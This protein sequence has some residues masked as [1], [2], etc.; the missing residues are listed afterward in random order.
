MLPEGISECCANSGLV[1]GE[2]LPVSSFGDHHPRQEQKLSWISRSL[3]RRSLSSFPGLGLTSHLP[4]CSVGCA[5]LRNTPGK[6]RQSPAEQDVTMIAEPTDTCFAGKE[7]LGMARH[8]PA[9]RSRVRGAPEPREDPQKCVTHNSGAS[10]PP[11]IKPHST[12]AVLL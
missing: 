1:H 4:A 8:F 3:F 6:S 5:K 12:Y 9:Q 11:L 2:L 7:G 10:S